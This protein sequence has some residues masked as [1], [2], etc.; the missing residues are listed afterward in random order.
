M[1]TKIKPKLVDYSLFHKPKIIPKKKI[2]INPSSNISFYSNVIGVL[3]LILGCL[4]LYQR[5]IDREKNEFNKQNTL[6]EFHQ[7]VKEKT[8]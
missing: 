7:Y 6:L 1:T 3:L 4:Y 8:I 2:E 5:L